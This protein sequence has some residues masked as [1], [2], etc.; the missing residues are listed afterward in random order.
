MG[1]NSKQIII[2]ASIRWHT[3]WQRPQA[4][5]KEFEKLG[6]KVIYIE[7]SG[8]RSLYDEYKLQLLKW[9][10][11]IKTEGDITIISPPCRWLP[12]GNFSGHLNYFNRRWR[13]RWLNKVFRNLA[14]DKP[15]LMVQS[16]TWQGDILTDINLRHSVLCYDCCD[17]YREFPWAKFHGNLEADEQAL[18]KYSDI[19]FVTSETLAR[20]A[21]HFASNISIVP[22]GVSDIFFD[23]PLKIP[24]DLSGIP[25]PIIG[26]IGTCGP[27]V[28]IELIQR[29]AGY[30][31][32]YSFVFIGPIKNKRFN[33]KKLYPNI[34]CL[35]EKPHQLIPSYISCMDV[36]MVPFAQC[37]ISFAAD[38]IKLYEYLSIGKPIVISGLPERYIE[39][40]EAGLIYLSHNDGEF[41]TKIDE[42]LKEVNPP[43][44]KRRKAFAGKHTWGARA[45]K[46]ENLLTE[47]KKDE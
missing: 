25:K 8:V 9:R 13:L 22:N 45:R 1:Y 35:G 26:F 18:L 41:L 34:Y 31:P 16:P 29:A 17:D 30:Y 3:L 2:F 32:A 23:P 5:A 46:I 11:Y 40:F 20:K 24:E 33:N 21:S 37:S 36:C 42:A 39:G 10:P 6:H 38:P 14:L 4:L 43:L 12:T 7:P 15:I 28:N 47:Y 44:Q 27:W 19:V